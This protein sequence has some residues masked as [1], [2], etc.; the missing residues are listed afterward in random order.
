MVS[1]TGEQTSR[2][3]QGHGARRKPVEP[4]YLEGLAGAG[5][6][7]STANDVLRYLR[8]QLEP[9]RTPLAEAIRLDSSAVGAA[10]DG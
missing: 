9:D 5:A 6:L 2:L 1:P 7:R 4:W 8:A 10:S 3:A